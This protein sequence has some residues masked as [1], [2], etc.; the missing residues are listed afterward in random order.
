MASCTS[1]AGRGRLCSDRYVGGLVI[2]FRPFV[3]GNGAGAIVWGLVFRLRPVVNPDSGF[4]HKTE[5][6][7]QPRPLVIACGVSAVAT[8]LFAR[9]CLPWSR[10]MALK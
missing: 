7:D 5:K 1:A 8:A 10:A 3:A 9:G 4:I 6:G 2:I